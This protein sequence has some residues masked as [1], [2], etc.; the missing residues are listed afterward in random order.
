MK[1]ILF[2]V[3]L[4]IAYTPCLAATLS[5]VPQIVTLP[6]GTS[7]GTTTLTWN[8]PEAAPGNVVLGISVNDTAE[9]FSSTF[10]YN[11]NS[12]ATYITPGNTFKF[13]LYKTPHIAGNPALATTTVYGLRQAGVLTASPAT[14]VVPTGSSTGSTT[15]TWRAVGVTN[16]VIGISM[17]GQPQVLSSQFPAS[18]SSPATY[19][20][21]GN[22]YNFKLYKSPYQPGSPSL[23]TIT[24]TGIAAPASATCNFSYTT[25]SPP[26][27]NLAV[28]GNN[29][30]ICLQNGN[31]NFSA[32]IQMAASQTLQSYTGDRAAVVVTS[33]AD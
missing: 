12:Q 19:I 2:V 11:G 14:V 25:G 30:T 15:L 3:M 20:V 17:N 10:S 4:L 21:A 22:T 9:V 23:A 27:A 8:A 5:A 18:G 28:L 24:V 26:P 1:R 16:V 6:P 32:P 33:T 29:K 31:Y 7:S 13:N